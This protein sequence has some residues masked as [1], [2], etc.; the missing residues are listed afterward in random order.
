MKAKAARCIILSIVLIAAA[1]F[2]R[3]YIIRKNFEKNYDPPGNHYLLT[4]PLPYTDYNYE[5]TVIS[6]DEKKIVCKAEH[7]YIN[8]NMD[9]RYSELSEGTVMILL[10]E[11][12]D[13]F[14]V[15]GISKGDTITFTTTGPNDID[16]KD[17]LT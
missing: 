11:D 17:R 1:F 12:N 9:G 6:A 7:D 5:A 10:A 15:D 13:N 16:I 8:K 14:W 2:V 4:Y 3:S